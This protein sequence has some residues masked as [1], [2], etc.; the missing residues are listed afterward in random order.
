MNSAKTEADHYA[1][2]GYDKDHDVYERLSEHHSNPNNAV[3]KLAEITS[4]HL[5]ENIRCKSTNEPFDWFN[6]IKNKSEVIATGATEARNGLKI[7]KIIVD[8]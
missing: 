1:V 4:S 8:I 2:Y 5:L 6:V 3:K 7:A